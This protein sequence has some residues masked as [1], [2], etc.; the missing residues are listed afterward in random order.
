MMDVVDENPI[1]VD[2]FEVQGYIHTEADFNICHELCE[3]DGCAAVS[4][5]K[6]CPGM[7]WFPSIVQNGGFEDGKCNGDVLGWAEYKHN[8]RRSGLHRGCING[9]V[10]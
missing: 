7:L 9:R 4:G 5:A 10:S 3:V 1:P 8:I 6:Q 2:R